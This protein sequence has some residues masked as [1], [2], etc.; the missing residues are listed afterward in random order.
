MFYNYLMLTNYS[1][2]QQRVTTP[3]FRSFRKCTEWGICQPKTLVL[4][5]S[6][7]SPWAGHFTSLGLSL[8]VFK[9]KLL[10]ETI[11]K[12]PFPIYYKNSI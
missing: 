10:K 2:I 11:S 7:I 3:L 6:L 4:G 1:L 9:R 8:D 5:L 12:S